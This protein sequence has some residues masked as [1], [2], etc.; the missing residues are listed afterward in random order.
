MEITNNS[1]QKIDI[2]I[3]GGMYKL[4]SGRGIKV[5]DNTTAIIICGVE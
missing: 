4:K 3:D 1:N 5:S 2:M